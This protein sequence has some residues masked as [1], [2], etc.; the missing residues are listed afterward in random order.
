MRKGV[1]LLSRSLKMILLAQLQKLPSNK[2]SISNEIPVWVIKQFANCYCEKIT[3]I[4]NNCHKENWFPNLMK[5]T[6]RSPVFKK[7]ANSSK[8]FKY[9]DFENRCYTSWFGGQMT[10]F[11]SKL[12][13]TLSPKNYYFL[14]FCKYN[15]IE[16]IFL[17]KIP[18][19]MCS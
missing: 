9:A 18:L 4:F 17:I 11:S 19:T 13:A 10:K 1:F 15:V 7:L 14:L 12:A 2:A 8:Y 16:K 6:K 3:N 5:V